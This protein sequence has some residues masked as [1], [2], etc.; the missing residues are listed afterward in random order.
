MRYFVARVVQALIVVWA[1]GTLV[2]FML[3]AVPGDPIAAM[4]ADV[5]PTAA[6]AIRAKL[7]LD[8]PVLVQYLFWLRNTLSGDLGQS[9]YGSH[10]AVNVQ[11]AEAVPRTVSLALVAF[12]VSFTL[13]L[14]AGIISAVKKDSLLDYGFNLAAFLGISMP[15]FWIGIVLIIVFAV[16]LRWFPAIG[17]K[18]MSAGLDQWLRYLILP[19]LA[20]GLPFSASIAR[21]T[22]SAMLE[23][24]GQDYISLARS[25][26]LNERRVIFRHALRNALIPVITVMGISLALLFSGSVVVEN[27]FA[28]K[29]LGRVLIQSILNRD[30][31][32][33]QGSILLVAVLLV[34]MNLAV[35]LLYR[36][37]DPRISYD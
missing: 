13:G 36:V 7:G 34:F 6:D 22:R 9:L 1:V 18:P 30:Y 31:P 28:I 27:V 33:V 2:F 26:G 19:G 20:V 29:G 4:L 15:S 5:D 21:L 3:R 14:S 25:K 35:D 24:L 17:Y 8:Q 23:V 16:N 10:Q 32:V 12:L 11:I 37:I